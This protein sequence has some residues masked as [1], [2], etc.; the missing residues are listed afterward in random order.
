MRVLALTGGI[1]SGK[2]S[3]MEIFRREVPGMVGFDADVCVRDLL[4]NDEGIIEKVVGVFGESC[5]ADEGAGIHRSELRKRVFG[6][7]ELR[8]LLESWIHPRVREECLEVLKS[9][10]KLAAPLFLAEI[11]LLFEGG[12]HFGQELNLT[13]AVTKETQRNRLMAR[14]GFSRSLCESILEAQLPMEIKIRRTEV[15]LWNEGPQVML[16]KQIQRFLK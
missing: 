7:P 4:A 16:E 3:A 1:A 6:N 14:N 15:V 5:R 13:V 2:S 10:G 11:P 9:A 12:F 8:Q